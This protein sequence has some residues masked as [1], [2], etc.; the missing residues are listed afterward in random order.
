[1][2]LGRILLVDDDQ[3]TRFLLNL[4][5]SDRGYHVS[6]AENGKKALETLS[7]D[8]YRFIVTDVQMPEMDGI[9]L[10][11]TLKDQGRLSKYSVAVMTARDID[12]VRPVLSDILGDRP[13]A[14]LQKPFDIEHLEHQLK[15]L[16]N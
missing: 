5:L 15:H 6:E 2:D 7:D 9:E 1:M 4:E 16:N 3:S 13:Y 8:G 14:L 12:D 11:R 10:L